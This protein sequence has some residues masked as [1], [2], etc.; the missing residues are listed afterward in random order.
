MKKLTLW[1]VAFGALPGGALFAQ[2]MTGIWQGALKAPQAPKGELRIVIKI[3]ISDADRL[4]AGMF[5]I[6]QGAQPIQATTVT[7]SGSTLKIT[8]ARINGN[9]DGRLSPD[10]RTITGTWTQGE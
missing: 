8:V 4:K 10:G 6:D 5:S 7:Q 3:S 9:Y 1:I 2:T